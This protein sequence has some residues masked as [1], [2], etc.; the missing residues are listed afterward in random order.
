M[1]FEVRTQ[2]MFAANQVWFRYHTICFHKV[3]FVHH[4]HWYI[5]RAGIIT[6]EEA[7]KAR[8]I[9]NHCGTLLC[10]PVL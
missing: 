4:E 6:M 2:E 9:C 8:Y 7:R 1:T 5:E 3:W 10:E